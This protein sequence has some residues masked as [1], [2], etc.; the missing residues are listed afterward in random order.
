MRGGPASGTTSRM[1]EIELTA[2][3]AQRIGDA[4]DGPSLDV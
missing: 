1:G 3:E 4:L 2:E